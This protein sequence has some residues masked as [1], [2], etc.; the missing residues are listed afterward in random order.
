MS[1]TG[2]PLSHVPFIKGKAEETLLHAK[3]QE[4]IALLRLDPDFYHST[5]AEL[6]HL[7][8]Q[9]VSGGIIIIDNFCAS[10]GSRLIGVQLTITICFQKKGKIFVQVTRASWRDLYKNFESEREIIHFLQRSGLVCSPSSI[11]NTILLFLAT[12][13]WRALSVL[14][15][16]HQGPSYP[17]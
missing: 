4:P 8:P 2:Y 10:Q 14:N 9:V 6:E 1:I 17:A 11:S 12:P 13:P 5:K 7:Y 3:P 16:A 15:N